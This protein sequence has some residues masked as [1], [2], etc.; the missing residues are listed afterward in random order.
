MVSGHTALPAWL[1]GL[2]AFAGNSDE[3]LFLLDSELY[4]RGPVQLI[5][6]PSWLQHSDRFHVRAYLDRHVFPFVL[7]IFSACTSFTALL[8]CQRY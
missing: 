1:Q 7:Y 3:Y 5:S 2:Q 8:G 4:R 6:V